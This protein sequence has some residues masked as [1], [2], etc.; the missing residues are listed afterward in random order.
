LIVPLDILLNLVNIGTLLAFTIVCAGVLYLRRSRP[1]LRRPFKVPFVPLFPVLGIL[2]CSFLAIFGLDQL[3]WK[4][5]GISLL[6]GLV[7]YFAYGFR[8]S[9]PEQLA[10]IPPELEEIKV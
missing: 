1:D 9:A 10:M 4:S 7:L 8:H 5:F 6:V 3:T 2:S